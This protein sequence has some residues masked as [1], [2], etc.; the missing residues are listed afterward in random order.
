LNKFT[1]HPLTFRVYIG[2]G[3]NFGEKV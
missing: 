2:F 1:E 3:D